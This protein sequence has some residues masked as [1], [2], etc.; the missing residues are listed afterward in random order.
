MLKWA[1]KALADT[2]GTEEPIYGPDAIQAVSKQGIPYT[3]LQK[4]DLKWKGLGGT[5][6][7]SCF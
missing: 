4:D 7:K 2:I 6:G 1:Q 5:N 3:E